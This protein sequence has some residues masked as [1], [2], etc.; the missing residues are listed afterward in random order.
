MSRNRLSMNQR[1]RLARGL[2]VS[3][4]AA[5]YYAATPEPEKEEQRT[6]E[7]K[8]FWTDDQIGMHSEVMDNLV[9][10]TDWE[11]QFAESIASRWKLSPKQ[12]SFL[13]QI[14]EEKVCGVD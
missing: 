5:K 11:R 4:G 3:H 9:R 14:F 13:Q 8:E 12:A 2:S 1:A 7:A 10:L 6:P